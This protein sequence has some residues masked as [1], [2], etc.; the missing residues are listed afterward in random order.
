[1]PSLDA[2]PTDLPSLDTLSRAVE[3]RLGAFDAAVR[4]QADVLPGPRSR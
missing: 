1:V 2:E 4:R 3:I